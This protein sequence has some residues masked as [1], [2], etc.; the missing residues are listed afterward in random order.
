MA[1]VGIKT[2]HDKGAISIKLHG[3]TNVFNVNT[4]DLR[5]ELDSYL[6]EHFFVNLMDLCKDVSEVL[7]EK[8]GNGDDIVWVETGATIVHVP[9]EPS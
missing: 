2:H 6:E 5:N 1:Y 7:V 3:P 8:Y 4:L 9:S